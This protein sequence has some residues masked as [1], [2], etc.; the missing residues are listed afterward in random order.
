M[1]DIKI[2]FFQISEDVCKQLELVLD[3]LKK[4]K[5][6]I[7]KTILRLTTTSRKAFQTDNVLTGNIEP[8]LDK[9][10]IETKLKDYV[11]HE[12]LHL[13]DYQKRG[14]QKGHDHTIHDN[15]YS[16]VLYLTT[17]VKGGE[18]VFKSNK[19]KKVV[20]PERGKLVLFDKFL[21]HYGRPTIDR[22]K[23]AVGGLRLIDSKINL[24]EIDVL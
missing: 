19:S 18:T 16:Y 22:K 3:V 23:A 8:I 2:K 11:C 5:L 24:F 12:T 7:D 10:L 14:Y 21:Y 6:G 13:I 1:D 20:M 9:I 4:N 17:C 15:E